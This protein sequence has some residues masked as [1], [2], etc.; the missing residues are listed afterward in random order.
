[1][2]KRPGAT[3]PFTLPSSRLDHLLISTTG[4]QVRSC[5]LLD[6]EMRSCTPLRS[7]LAK[8]AIPNVIPRAR[9][10]RARR[11]MSPRAAEGHAA[12]NCRT[13]FVSDHFGLT[14]RLVIP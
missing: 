12:G 14:A 8:L 4:V 10:A 11:L 1:M 3:A 2:N 9:R 7:A 13:V 6:E 5:R